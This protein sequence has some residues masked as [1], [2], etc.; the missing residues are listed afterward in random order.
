[1]NEL[2]EQCDHPVRFSIVNYETAMENELDAVDYC[3]TCDS[4][5]IWGLGWVEAPEP[6]ESMKIRLSEAAEN[7]CACGELLG[8]CM[9]NEC[10]ACQ[11]KD[12]LAKSVPKGFWLGE[13]T[14]SGVGRCHVFSE[15]AGNEPY[16]FLY[17][18][19]CGASTGRG[20]EVVE[21][22]KREMCS[23]CE[24]WLMAE[25]KMTDKS[26]TNRKPED[27]PKAF[28][29][30]LDA[31]A[32]NRMLGRYKQRCSG[33]ALAQAR[34]AIESI[35]SMLK[36]G[37]W[38]DERDVL[39]ARLYV[40]KLGVEPAEALAMYETILKSYPKLRHIL[41]PILMGE[42]EAPTMYAVQLNDSI[43]AVC[44]EDVRAQ[45]IAEAV[46]AQEDFHARHVYVR[47]FKLNEWP[48]HWAGKEPV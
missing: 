6:S 26:V 44:E 19:V 29:N 1:M 15:Y 28:E 31:Q 37:E 20:A 23:N 8:E 40:E 21:R 18:A 12:D 9:D 4:I 36:H 30:S 35:I 10:D 46:K 13:L 11:H 42:D 41:K 43:V 5:R 7:K 48:E 25:R 39:V 38:L 3:V 34:G 22:P 27:Y 32:I 24:D 2:R 16:R 14:G 33:L 47:E 17:T 45:Q